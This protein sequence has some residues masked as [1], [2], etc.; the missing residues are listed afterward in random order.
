MNS[1]S[2]SCLQTSP[3]ANIKKLARVLRQPPTRCRPGGWEQQPLWE[4]PKTP[5]ES[6]SPISTMEPK[7]YTAEGRENNKLSPA[8]LLGHWWK[9][10]AAGN[11]HHYSYVIPFDEQFNL[12]TACLLQT[13]LQDYGPVLHSG[14]Q[15]KPLLNRHCGATQRAGTFLGL[16]GEGEK[17]HGPRG[18]GLWW[19]KSFKMKTWAWL[20]MHKESQRTGLTIIGVRRMGYKSLSMN[21]LLN[22]TSL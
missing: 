7:P 9:P 19:K 4:K 10:T 13:L 20:W 1:H 3:A 8:S 14:S 15:P 16:G 2:D 12:K 17:N 11:F 18:R 6:S 5:S 21:F 22:V